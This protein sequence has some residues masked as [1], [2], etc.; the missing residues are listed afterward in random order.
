MKNINVNIPKGRVQGSLG[1][2]GNSNPENL[3]PTQHNEKL[4][5]RCPEETD[6][7]RPVEKP[8]DEIFLGK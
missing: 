6:P 7:P 3:N 5:T 4:G 8:I 2:S 1:E